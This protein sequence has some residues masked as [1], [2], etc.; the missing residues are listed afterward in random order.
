MGACFS[1]IA[2]L[3][4]HAA[5]RRGA[6]L[7]YGGM[8][9]SSFLSGLVFSPQNVVWRP[10]GI[11]F[12][13]TLSGLLH[14]TRYAIRAG[15][16]HFIATRLGRPQDFKAVIVAVVVCDIP[17]LIEIVL[18]LILPG[19]AAPDHTAQMVIRLTSPALFFSQAGLSAPILNLVDTFELFNLIRLALLSSTLRSLSSLAF[20]WC[21]LINVALD[22]CAPL[23]RVLF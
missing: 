16:F 19:F 3:L 1:A 9:A 7:V 2:A 4:S 20:G 22:L 12:L 8:V 14:L 21:A 10:F 18:S 15:M 13:L 6:L 11:I 17:V 5:T 23:L